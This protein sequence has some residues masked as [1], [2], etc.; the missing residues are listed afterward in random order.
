MNTTYQ[1]TPKAESFRV[2]EPK[3]CTNCGDIIEE[4]HET[5]FTQCDKCLRKTPHN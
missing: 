3:I 2:L 1:M 5:Y 4:M